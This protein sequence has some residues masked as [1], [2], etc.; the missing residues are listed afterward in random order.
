MSQFLAR[1]WPSFD[2]VCRNVHSL[3]GMYT[4][5][6]SSERAEK[7]KTNYDFTYLHHYAEGQESREEGEAGGCTV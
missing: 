1:L 6:A 5:Q 4:D 2:S 3:P 7:T